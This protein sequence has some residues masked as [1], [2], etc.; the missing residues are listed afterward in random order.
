MASGTIALT[1][2]DRIEDNIFIGEAELTDEGI[3][4]LFQGQG[5]HFSHKAPRFKFTP[6]AR[7]V[8]V[9]VGHGFICTRTGVVLLVAVVVTVVGMCFSVA[10][11][12]EEIELH[13]TLRKVGLL[14]FG[15]LGL[16]LDV[17]IHSLRR[18]VYLRLDGPGGEQ[19]FAN[20]KNV[21]RAEVAQALKLPAKKYAYVALRDVEVLA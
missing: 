6:K 5:L 14:I 8:R 16:G 13:E 1:M 4:E 19:R 2:P 18:G 17:V 21:E 3:F 20:G 7:I 10:G 9:G 11:A 15:G 12:T